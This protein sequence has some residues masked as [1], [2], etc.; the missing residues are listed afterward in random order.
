MKRKE[1]EREKKVKGGSVKIYERERER[2]KEREKK[3]QK[4]SKKVKKR[5]DVRGIFSIVK[6]IGH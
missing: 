2:E 5:S 4:M 6:V 3:G 1:S